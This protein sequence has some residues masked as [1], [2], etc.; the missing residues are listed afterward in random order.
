M[1]DSLMEV[2][3][4]GVLAARSLA[5]V[6]GRPAESYPGSVNGDIQATL[7]LT[8]PGRSAAR[9]KLAG[10]HVD[11]RSLTGAPLKLDR[12]DLQGEGNALQIRELTLDWAQQKATVRGAIAREA[13]AFGT[14]LEVDSPGVVIDALR[15]MRAAKAVDAPA[16]KDS[17]PRKSA[18]LW[19]RRS[20]GRSL[21][22]DFVEYRGYQVRTYAQL[23]PWST[24]RWQSMSPGLRF[25]GIAFPLSLRMT[26]GVRRQ[27]KMA[28]KRISRGRSFQ[29]LGGKNVVISGNF[30]MTS[31]LTAKGSTERFG[32]S[33]AEHLT[34]SVKVA[35]RDGEIRKMKL[36][37]NILSLKSVRDVVKGDV[38]FGANGFAYRSITVGAKIA[39]R[40][41]TVEQAALDSPALGL[42]AA[43][44]INLAS[45]DSRLT[46]L[47][48]PFSTLDRIVRKIPILGYVI[49]G[50]FTSIPVGVSGYI[51]DPLVAPLGPERSGPK[52]WEFSN[53]P[54]SYRAKWSS[55]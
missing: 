42:A 23:Q 20:K 17:K 19:S 21:R 18:V 33:L 44:T 16:D 48:A 50:A 55:R 45:Y 38:G 1:H 30:D 49:G 8:Q 47:V 28:V 43:G 25:C 29:C 35:T 5:P 9:G 40:E 7:D 32:E 27:C 54:S 34:G 12:F 13:N 22:T 6:F 15:G 2:G 52:S 11:L 14:N 3:F 4:A 39:N 36:L 26:Q 37:G 41:L 31:G 10:T 51:R 24:K 53:V 46:V